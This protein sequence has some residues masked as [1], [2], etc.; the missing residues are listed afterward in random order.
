MSPKVA[1]SDTKVIQSRP[2]CRPKVQ[3]VVKSP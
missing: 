2:K 3:K 1:P